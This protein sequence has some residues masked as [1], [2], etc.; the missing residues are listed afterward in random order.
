MDLAKHIK[1]ICSKLEDAGKDEWSYVM[2]AM[3]RKINA[4]KAVEIK[5]DSWDDFSAWW[6]QNRSETLIYSMI[7]ELGEDST[8]VKEMQDILHQQE[9]LDRK[10]HGVYIALKSGSPTPAP[11]PSSPLSSDEESAIEELDLSSEPSE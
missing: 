10:L 9:E 11:G 4:A 5:L 7:D 6:A 2:S 1:A 8:V 3:Q